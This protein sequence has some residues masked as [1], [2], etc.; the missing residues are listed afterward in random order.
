MGVS[1]SSLSGAA[2]GRG[3]LGKK[4]A[5]G[6]NGGWGGVGSPPNMRLKSVTGRSE[7]TRYRGRRGLGGARNAVA[8]SGCGRSVSAPGNGPLGVTCHD[9]L[10]S[11]PS[12]F[13]HD[14]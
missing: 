7:G 12:A 5:I 1:S 6:G 4:T 3:W 9:I 14:F 10:P 13:V 8:E 2:N 11:G